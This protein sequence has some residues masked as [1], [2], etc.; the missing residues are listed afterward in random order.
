MTS[1]NDGSVAVDEG[2]AT[3]ENAPPIGVSGMDVFDRYPGAAATTIKRLEAENER[4]RKA[5]PTP[6]HGEAVATTPHEERWTVRRRMVLDD[7]EIQSL[8][9]WEPFAV[10]N[11]WLYMRRRGLSE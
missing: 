8:D 5:P 2:E 6:Q 3:P 4:L 10:D 7:T 11:S 9:G 1:P